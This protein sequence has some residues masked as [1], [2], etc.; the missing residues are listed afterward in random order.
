MAKELLKT[1][2]ILGLPEKKFPSYSPTRWWSI[3]NLMETC[4]EQ[5][6]FKD[7]EDAMKVYDLIKGEAQQLNINFTQTPPKPKHDLAL[8]F[9]A[10]KETIPL[11]HEELVDRELSAYMSVPSIHVDEDPLLWWKLNETRF[12]YLALGGLIVEDSRIS[13]TSEHVE[14][15]IMISINKK[16]ILLCIVATSVPSER[17]FSKAGLVLNEKRSLLKN[18]KVGKILFLNAN[19]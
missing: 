8:I 4:V 15:L 3:L 6:L 11:T 13:L 16:H 12:P 9:S 14:Q 18:K 2:K 1:Q 17:T 5:H 10:K 7:H 19:L